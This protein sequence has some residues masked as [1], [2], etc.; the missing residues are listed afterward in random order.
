HTRWPRDWSSDVCSSD[1]LP[2]VLLR[3]LARQVERV[4]HLD[5]HALVLGR[6]IN[7]VLTD[8]LLAARPVGLVDADL[9]LRK[10]HAQPVLL[11]VLDLEVDADLLV[12][13]GHAVRSAVVVLRAV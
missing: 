8:E 10:R 12:R 2:E 3:A 11:A 7:P 5:L 9:T 4:A 1:L 13:D 6:V